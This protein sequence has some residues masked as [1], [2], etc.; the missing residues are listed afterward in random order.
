MD[1]FEDGAILDVGDCEGC[2]EYVGESDGDFVGTLE[3]D[4]EGDDDTWV[5][6]FELGAKEAARLG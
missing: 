2:D 3:G 5:V 6:G 1:G 4:A